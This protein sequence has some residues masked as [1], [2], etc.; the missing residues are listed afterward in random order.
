MHNDHYPLQQASLQ[1]VRP[2]R[3]IVRVIASDNFDL[4]DVVIG[5]YVETGGTV[6][7]TTVQG[8]TRTVE[9]SGFSI[10]P[11]GATRVHATGTTASGIDAMVLA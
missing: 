7:L 3:D 8:E 10:L 9:V 2:A 6:V 4:A 5:L 11:V 1:F